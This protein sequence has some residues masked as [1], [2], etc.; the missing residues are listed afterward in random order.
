MTAKEA[1]EV[2]RAMFG[3]RVWVE[4]CAGKWY[5]THDQ[6]DNT[7]GVTYEKPEHIVRDIVKAVGFAL[8]PEDW[9]KEKRLKT[10][11]E[12][13]PGE[14]FLVQIDMRDCDLEEEVETSVE[15]EAVVLEPAIEAQAETSEEPKI[16]TASVTTLAVAT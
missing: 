3:S 14:P 2:C 8:L 1:Q 4:G 11:A 6:D 10:W 9:S 13:H 5:M 16:E 12:I 7:S 15:T